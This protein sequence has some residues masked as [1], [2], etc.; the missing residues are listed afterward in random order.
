[1]TSTELKKHQDILR[2]ALKNLI[3]WD[4]EDVAKGLHILSVEIGR[5]NVILEKLEETK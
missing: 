2:E 5:L 4:D 3:A 1:M